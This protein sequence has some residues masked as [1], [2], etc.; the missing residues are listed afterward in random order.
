MSNLQ[1]HYQ[2]KL[3]LHTGGKWLIHGT[4]HHKDKKLRNQFLYYYVCSR[5]VLVS[6]ISNSIILLSLQ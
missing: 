4:L 2:F 6:I 1:T 3:Y 5:G